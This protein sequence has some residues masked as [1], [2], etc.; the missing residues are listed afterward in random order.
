MERILNKYKSK[1]PFLAFFL[2]FLLISFEICAQ[3][4][5][6][7][8]GQAIKKTM[9]RA[10]DSIELRKQKDLI[11]YAYLIMHKNPEKRFVQDSSKKSKMQFSGYPAIIYNPVT[12]AAIALNLLDAFSTYNDGKTNISTVLFSPEY[13]QKKQS[14]F[15]IQSNIFTKDNRYIFF[16]DWRYMIFP[17]ETWGIGGNT[18]DSNGYN[19]YYKYSRFYETVF[20]HIA[21]NLYLGLGFQFDYHWD[22]SEELVPVTSKK[23]DFEKYGFNKSS[24]SSGLVLDLQYDSRKNTINPEAGSTYANIVLRQNSTFIGSNTNWS[25]LLIDV[26]KYL[27]LPSNAILAF[28]SYDYYTLRGNPPYLDLPGTASDTYGNTGRGYEQSRFVGKNF[29]DLEVELRYHITKNGLIGGVLFANVE[30]AS[31]LNTNRL[32]TLLPGAG[33]GLRI[34]FNKYSKTNICIDYGW[35]LRGSSAFFFNLGEMF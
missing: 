13:T 14:I 23:T 6:D 20:K 3:G 19:V 8:D 16:G 11:D 27:P 2:C 15:P 22:I 12:G 18:V 28:W 5:L 21:K 30:S 7:K 34:K 17:Q 1:Y 29:M 33:L 9:P 31:E 35:G 32:Q 25:S 24:I 26:R 4:S 10:A